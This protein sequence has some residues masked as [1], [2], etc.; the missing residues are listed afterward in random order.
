[1]FI[2]GGHTII[3]TLTVVSSF[4]LDA[5]A[6][7]IL[8]MRRD[9]EDPA[10]AVGVRRRRR[11][12]TRGRGWRVCYHRHRATARSLLSALLTLLLLLLLMRVLRLLSR[13]VPYN[14]ANKKIVFSISNQ[15]RLLINHHYYRRA[16]G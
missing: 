6:I 12:M 14:S 13:F 8:M 7:W 9:P 2:T 11:R 5:I 3:S 4:P 16:Q 15:L 1:M 10:Y